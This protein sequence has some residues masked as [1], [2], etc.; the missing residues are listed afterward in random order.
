MKIYVHDQGL[1]KSCS[2]WGYRIMIV[3]FA[4]LA[5]FSSYI[6][7]RNSKP[8]CTDLRAVQVNEYTRTLECVY[9]LGD[10]QEDSVDVLIVK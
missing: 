1:V 9:D 10:K 3:L 4:L 7:L 8:I 2:H 6:A 5:G